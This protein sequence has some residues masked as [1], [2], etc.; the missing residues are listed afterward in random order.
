MRHPDGVRPRVRGG[1]GSAGQP[2]AEELGVDVML[3]QSWDEVWEG[4]DQEVKAFESVKARRRSSELADEKACA[5]SNLGKHLSRK[6][7]DVLN[8][9][10]VR[11]QMFRLS[12]QHLITPTS[13][14]PPQ[15]ETARPLMFARPGELERVAVHDDLMGL[16]AEFAEEM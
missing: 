14:A 1:R 3:A 10:N 16:V 12:E 4:R 13:V 7:T 8:V 9:D 5:K 15:S 2:D 11:L 6:A